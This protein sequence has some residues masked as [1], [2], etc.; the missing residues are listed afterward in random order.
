MK[1][2]SYTSLSNI[3]KNHKYN[4]I[5]PFSLFIYYDK[6]TC[7]LDYSICKHINK[8]SNLSLNYLENEDYFYTNIPQNSTIKLLEYSDYCYTY[9]ITLPNKYTFVTTFNIENIDFKYFSN[10]YN[11]ITNPNYIMLKEVE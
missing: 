6:N 11:F 3:I 8:N 10:Y 5:T 4:L 9:E 2:Y 7:E 1:N